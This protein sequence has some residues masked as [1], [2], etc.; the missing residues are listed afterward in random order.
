MDLNNRGRGGRKEGRKEG[1]AGER[2][3]VRERETDKIV[4]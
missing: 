1:G 3:T 4:L 2:E